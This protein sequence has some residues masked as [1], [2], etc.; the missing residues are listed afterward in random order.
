MIATSYCKSGPMYTV[1][2]RDGM[3]YAITY[4][5]AEALEKLNE[6]NKE[7]EHEKYNFETE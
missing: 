4:N 5:Y 6:M 7:N 1:Y 2:T 3:V